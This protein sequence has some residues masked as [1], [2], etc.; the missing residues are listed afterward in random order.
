MLS[1][2]EVSIDQAAEDEAERKRNR[3]KLWTPPRGYRPEPG[4]RVR[5]PGAGMTAARAATLMQQLA[6][7]DAQ[8]AG[9]RTR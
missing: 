3:A 1:A 9:M 7:E 2:A 4:R 6:A 5:L 8:V